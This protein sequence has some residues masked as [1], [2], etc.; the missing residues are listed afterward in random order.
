MNEKLKIII[1]ENV[2]IFKK[3][4]LKRFKNNEIKEIFDVIFIL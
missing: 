2:K 3:A 1:N 4:L